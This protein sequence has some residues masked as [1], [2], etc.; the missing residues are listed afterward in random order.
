MDILAS[1]SQGF[2]V[3]LDPANLMYCFIGVL[4]GTIVGVLPGLGHSGTMA[5][6]LPLTF[7]F[8]DA[9]AI[10]LLAGIYYGSMYGGSTTSILLNIPGEAPSIVTCI[11]GYQMHR[12]GRGGAALGIAAFGSFIAG[13]VGVI[14][15]TFLS[16]VLTEWALKF[17]PPEYFALV[18]LGVA[19]VTYLSQGSL[20][21]GLIMVVLGMLIATIGMDPMRGGA[22]YEFGTSYLLGGV[23]VIVIAMGMFALNEILHM[24][25]GPAETGEVI[26]PPKRLREL[27]PNREEWKQSAMPIARGSVIG[28]LIGIIPGGGAILSTFAS[29]A[30]EKKLS[31][32]PEL[33]GTG[34]IA[35]VAGPESANNG[36][37]AGAFV[38]LMSLG[39][40]SNVPAALLLGALMIH[41][42]TPGPM[43][44]QMR[45]DV[46]WGVIASMYIGNVLLLILNLP[47]IGL[48]TRIAYV[49]VRLLVPILTFICLVGVY[50][51]GY[52]RYDIL[53]M[54]I[55]GL[56]SFAAKLAGFQVAPFIFGFLLGPI[57]E[58]SFERSLTISQGEFGIFVV[59]PISIS[60]LAV[61]ALIWLAPLFSMLRRRLKG[62]SGGPLPITY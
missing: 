2:A 32:T 55:F 41:G 49:P 61:A 53:V 4:L 60:V 54:I 22:R 45:P 51:T 1:L 29:Y 13:T 36:A 48:F 5:I 11:D 24:M 23:D 62:R 50:L 20:L 18:M 44:M 12:K 39:I 6:I 34:M 47:L 43:F 57:V 19:L 15:I 10:M 9:G 7:Y 59:S 25:V 30:I 27:L 40:P 58:T 31:K 33:F 37:A 35:G 8:K 17:G 38:P 26:R 42:I 56:F 3:A 52:D 16:S 46:F 21:K 14:G 28:F